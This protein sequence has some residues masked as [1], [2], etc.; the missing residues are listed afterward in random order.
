MKPIL[1]FIVFIS[2]FSSCDDTDTTD[3]PF[4]ND[5]SKIE[6]TLIK[7]NRF[8]LERDKELIESYVKRRVWKMQTTESGLWYEVYLKTTDKKVES[9]NIIKYNYNTL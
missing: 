3:Q 2:V 1:Y 7:A 8:L 4:F 6:D 9:G 5:E